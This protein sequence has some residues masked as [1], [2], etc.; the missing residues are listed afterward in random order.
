MVIYKGQPHR[1]QPKGGERGK[2]ESRGPNRTYKTQLTTRDS[3]PF[4]QEY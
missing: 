4:S 3:F 1:E 2:Q